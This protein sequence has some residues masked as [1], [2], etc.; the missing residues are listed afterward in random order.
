MTEELEQ[1]LNESHVEVARKLKKPIKLV[2]PL[3]NLVQVKDYELI[4]EDQKKIIKEKDKALEQKD[5]EIAELRK[6]LQNK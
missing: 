6:Q 4:V 2:F 5:E 3:D 1:M